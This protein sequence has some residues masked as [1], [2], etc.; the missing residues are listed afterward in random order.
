[1]FWP[2][3]SFRLP[4][5]VYSL[6]QLSLQFWSNLPVS[7]ILHTFG[8]DISRGGL[9]EA[10]AYIGERKHTRQANEYRYKNSQR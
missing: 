1:V 9:E 3:T 6:G 7:Q 10:T 5:S 2:K 4:F 8:A